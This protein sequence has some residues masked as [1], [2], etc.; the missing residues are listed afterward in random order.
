[1]GAEQPAADVRPERIQASPDAVSPSSHLP[2]VLFLLL[3][4]WFPVGTVF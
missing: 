4:L 3:A 1:M 2:P